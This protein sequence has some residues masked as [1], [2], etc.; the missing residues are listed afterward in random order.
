MYHFRVTASMLPLNLLAL[1]LIF[2]CINGTNCGKSVIVTLALKIN[3]NKMT[4]TK[5]G[6]DREIQLRMC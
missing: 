3:I 1:C 5:T 2:L 6:K 4:V